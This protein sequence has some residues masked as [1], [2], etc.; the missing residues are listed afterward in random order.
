MLRKSTFFLSA[1]LLSL[2]V[3]AMSPL[4]EDDLSTFNNPISLSINPER[5]VRENQKINMVDKSE[6]FYHIYIN[7]IRN[8]HLFNINLFDDQTDTEERFNSN[9]PD[10]FYGSGRYN[11]VFNNVQIFIIDPLTGK[12]YT[13]LSLEDTSSIKNQIPSFNLNTWKDFS[14]IVNAEDV[15]G[16]YNNTQSVTPNLEYQDDYNRTYD[17]AYIY[18]IMSGNTEMKDTYIDNR[19]SII[20]SGSW[21][22]IKIH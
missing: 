18:K 17:G 10:Y 9:I 1:L 8:D 11:N 6:L 20:K 15:N 12:D 22:N 7:L 2:A 3:T 21:V 13:T 5:I 4:S 19:D 16:N 14:T